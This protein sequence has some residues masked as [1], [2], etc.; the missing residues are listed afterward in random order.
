MAGAE[1]GTV[2]AG[3]LRELWA[4]DER[5]TIDDGAGNTQG[6]WQER[7]R[8]A[9]RAETLKGGETVMAARLEGRQP[10]AATIRYSAKSAL[11]TSD[12]R[13]RDVRSGVTFAISTVTTR[14]RRD[15]RDLIVI[16]GPA[17]G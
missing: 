17:D 4:F 6:E 14:P 8:C 16:E 11:V 13:A 7:F 10:Y 15:Y 3:P 9:A 1:R 5:I 2:G 12:W